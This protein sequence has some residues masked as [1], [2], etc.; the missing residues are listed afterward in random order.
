[1]GA[2]PHF[3]EPKLLRGPVE[4]K[5]NTNYECEIRCDYVGLGRGCAGRDPGACVSLAS[6]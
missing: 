5:K 1:M 2:D 6:W 4:G 3:V